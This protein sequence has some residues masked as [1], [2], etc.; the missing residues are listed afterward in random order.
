[1]TGQGPLG[2]KAGWTCGLPVKKASPTV[3]FMCHTCL[4]TVGDTSARRSSTTRLSQSVVRLS[5]RRCP[6]HRVNP[7]S[8]GLTG[9]GVS[10]ST[11]SSVCALWE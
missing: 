9:M 3:K 6:S 10:T 4:V 2:S 11:R 8:R 5:G 1:M 7:L